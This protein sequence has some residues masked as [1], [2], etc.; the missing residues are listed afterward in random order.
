[1]RRST[2][3]R[4]DAIVGQGSRAHQSSCVEKEARPEG[5]PKFT[6]Q[7]ELLPVPRANLAALIVV[8]VVIWIV[9]FYA[10]KVTPRRTVVPTEMEIVTVAMAATV[11]VPTAMAA[12]HFG[13]A[14]FPSDGRTGRVGRCQRRR[15]RGS[16]RAKPN[17][18]S[19]NSAS[20]IFDR[21][22]FILSRL[23][24]CFC[25]SCRA[26]PEIY[27]RSATSRDGDHLWSGILKYPELFRNSEI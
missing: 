8:F 26:K 16:E 22:H 5:A 4:R 7:I 1:M 3:C 17:H 6:S 23:S 14:G 27:G 15:L 2:A 11:A 19:H 12:A 18:R 24:I 21:C 9:Y 13:N 10:L 25:P 20:N